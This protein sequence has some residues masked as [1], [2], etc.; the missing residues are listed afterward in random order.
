MSLLFVLELKLWKQYKDMT[1]IT[2]ETFL[3]WSLIGAFT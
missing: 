3:L 1:A 2:I